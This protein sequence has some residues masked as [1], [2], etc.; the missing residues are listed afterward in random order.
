MVWF[1][2]LHN[3]EMCATPALQHPA[4]QQ[5]TA[6]TYAALSALVALLPLPAAAPQRGLLGQ[7]TAV[8]TLAECLLGFLLPTAA[9]AVWESRLYQHY[10]RHW[11]R[12]QRH[13]P[14]EERQEEQAAAQGEEAAA[15]PS[16][17]AVAAH[18]GWCLATPEAA[19]AATAAAAGTP[20]L[21][22]LPFLQ[23]PGRVAAGFYRLVAAC[24]SPAEAADYAVAAAALVLLLAAAWQAVLLLN[25]VE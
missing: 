18:G 13:Q 3:R 2:W 1:V 4:A 7:C 15:G 5:A 11:A 6:A 10:C 9:L 20:D 23:P 17:S 14:Q 25:A 21:T 22:K 24:C 16:T 12:W 19:A 8:L